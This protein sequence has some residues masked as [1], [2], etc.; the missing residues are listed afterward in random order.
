MSWLRR[1]LTALQNRPYESRIKILKVTVAAVALILLVIWS[2]TVKYRSRPENSEQKS[3]F[4]P[5]IENLKNL[6]DA[7]R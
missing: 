1:K 7:K 4:A 5:I 2:V 3:K 6:K